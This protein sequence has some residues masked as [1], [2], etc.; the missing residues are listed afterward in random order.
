MADRHSRSLRH[1]RFAGY[2]C[3]FVSLFTYTSRAASAL[4][5]GDLIDN[6]QRKG[7]C[8]AQHGA[9]LWVNA[10]FPVIATFSLCHFAEV[11][12]HDTRA[13]PTSYVR[14][15]AS[16]HESIRQRISTAARTVKLDLRGL[17]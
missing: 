7:Q 4:Y 9:R 5:G 12:F 14:E 17:L 15:G 8:D 6:T 1:L 2:L 11:D 16:P 3:L 10:T 13:C